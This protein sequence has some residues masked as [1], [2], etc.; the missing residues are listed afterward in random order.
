VGSLEK[1]VLE[2]AL[3]EK[4]QNDINDQIRS[5]ETSLEIQRLETSIIKMID[6]ET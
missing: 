3:L 5:A 6:K 1:I 4:V 2:G